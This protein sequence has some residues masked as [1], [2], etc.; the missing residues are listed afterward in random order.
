MINITRLLSLHYLT[1]N[2]MVFYGKSNGLAFYA[3][4]VMGHAKQYEVLSEQIKM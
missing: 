2:E 3:S 4:F 1:I